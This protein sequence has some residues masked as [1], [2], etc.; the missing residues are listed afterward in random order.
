M[1]TGDSPPA[2]LGHRVPQLGKGFTGPWRGPQGAEAESRRDCAAAGRGWPTSSSPP[3]SPVAPSFSPMHTPGSPWRSRPRT[4]S[5]PCCPKHGT[6]RPAP[7]PLRRRCSS[8]GGSGGWFRLLPHATG[9]PLS[10]PNA[11]PGVCRSLSSFPLGASARRIPARS[12]LP[13]PPT[14][15]QPHLALPF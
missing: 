13:P 4:R 8:W 2:S 7:L 12:L 11:P 5:H 6:S 1:R 9:L 15:A 14:H 10:A 3:S